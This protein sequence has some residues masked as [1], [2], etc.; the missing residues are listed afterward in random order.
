MLVKEY[1]LHKTAKKTATENNLIIADGIYNNKKR[2]FDFTLLNDIIIS[3]QEKEVIKAD[4]LKNVTAADKT[5]FYT[6]VFDNFTACNGNVLYYVHRVFSKDGRHLYNIFQLAKVEH[7]TKERKSVYENYF[8]TTIE[9]SDDY[10][11][12]IED[13]E[14]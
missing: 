2:L 7:I 5:S 8:A 3:D 14:L 12:P 11:M 9:A 13:I 10:T 1:N 6:K 4:A